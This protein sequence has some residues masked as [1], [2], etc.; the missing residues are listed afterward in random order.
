VALSEGVE[1]FKV[2]LVHTR[3]TGEKVYKF[4]KHLAKFGT[5][6]CNLTGSQETGGRSIR[7]KEAGKSSSEKA[8][9]L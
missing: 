9:A 1:E 3:T 7:N 6:E 2:I 4:R 5:G 8:E